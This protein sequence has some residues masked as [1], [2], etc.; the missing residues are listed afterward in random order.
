MMYVFPSF[1][2]HYLD[3]YPLEELHWPLV[4]KLVLDTLQDNEYKL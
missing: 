3:S 1:K 4:I 2:Y